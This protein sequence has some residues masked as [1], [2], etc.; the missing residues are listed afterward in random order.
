[1]KTIK[2]IMIAFLLGLQ[3]GCIDTKFED[4]FKISVTPDAVVNKINVRL[5][6]FNTF[7]SVDDAR[8]TFTGDNAQYV[9]NE[10]GRSQ[11]YEKDEYGKY[12]YESH[13]FNAEDGIFSFGVERKANASADN[14]IAVTM[15]ISATGFNDKVI[16]VVFDGAEE[17]QSYPVALFPTSGVSFVTKA[18][19]VNNTFETLAEACEVPDD[20]V[21]FSFTNNSLYA[22]MKYAIYDDAG[23]YLNGGAFPA[24]VGT[25]T[26]TGAILKN[27]D[28]YGALKILL[29]GEYQ[30][31]LGRFDYTTFTFETL[32]DKQTISVCE[33]IE[34]GTPVESDV[35]SDETITDYNLDLTIDCDANIILNGYDVYYRAA[36]ETNFKYF[37]TIKNGWIKGTGPALEDDTIY[38]FRIKY[39]GKFRTTPDSGDNSIKGSDVKD[40]GINLNQ[41]GLCTEVNKIING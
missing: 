18:G 22:D 17:A 26:I 40:S 19:K 38:Q 5:L 25:F 35:T 16:E 4:E 9:Y 28:F 27:N 20:A 29:N 31:S 3:V 15:T 23:N 21:V 39:D 6:D 37:Q 36:G 10:A 30:F 24:P 1:M 33:I 11:S 13:E 41:D 34:T 2:Y 8:I 12:I 14:P 7:L 32:I